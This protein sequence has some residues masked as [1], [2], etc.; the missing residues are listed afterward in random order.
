MMLRDRL[1]E[2]RDI[3]AKKKQQRSVSVE[4]GDIKAGGDRESGEVF[5]G[6]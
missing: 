1:K 6:R 3:N 5:M 4:Y 2:R